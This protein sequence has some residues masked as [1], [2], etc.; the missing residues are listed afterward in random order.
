MTGDRRARTIPGKHKFATNGAGLDDAG[1]E[2]LYEGWPSRVA[3]QTLVFGEVGL[4]VHK[5]AGSKAAYL[6]Q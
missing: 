4:D 2:L 6:P 3:K 5:G 1:L